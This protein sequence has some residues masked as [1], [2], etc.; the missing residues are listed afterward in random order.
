MKPTSRSSSLARLAGA[1]LVASAFLLAVPAATLATICTVPDNGS[2]TADLPPQSP[3]ATCTSGYLSPTDVHAIIDGLPPG[4][5]IDIGAEHNEFICK[6]SSPV[7]SFTLPTADADCDQAGGSLG[8][9][10]ECAS[11]NLRMQMHG[12][13]A[14]TGYTRN[15]NLPID[16]ETHIAPR[17][18]GNP[19]QSFDTE[20]V[21]LFGQLPPGDPDF[22]LLRITAGSGF[23]MPSP[24]HTTLTR[25]PGG[26]WNVDSFFD[27]T[28]RIDFVGAPGG[29]VGGMSGSTTGT[30]RM[31]IGETTT[32]T[33]TTMG[34]TTTT[35]LP[36][37]VYD[38]LEC[39]KAK[40]PRKLAGVVDLPTLAGTPYD[41]AGCT[42]G[43]AKKYCTPAQKVV[44][45]SSV[46]V[47]PLP[48]PN[49]TSDYICYKIKCPKVD[50]TQGV[51]DQFG[52]RSLSK[53]K[54]AELCV[55]AVKTP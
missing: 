44:V 9:E 47:T 16:F 19:V 7:C 48:G 53:M 50:L 15:L 5:T 40:D 11:S 14:L 8:G 18:P 29:P 21:R 52:P 39:F 36:P 34:S 33:T 43:S 6:S 20:M 22:D 32:A 26:S 24:G 28:Y 30:I 35:T 41:A 17:T 42:I 45:S 13:G 37:I 25:L 46:T 31:A 3:T 1:T 10:E 2:G 51:Q 38:H 49:L 54:Q 12:T 27:I 4:T 55:P 23:G